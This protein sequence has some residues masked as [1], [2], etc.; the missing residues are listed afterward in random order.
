MYV[1]IAAKKPEL[2]AFV[3]I[4]ETSRR[5]RVRLHYVFSTDSVLGLLTT[6]GNNPIETLYVRFERKL[7]PGLN[8]FS[9]SSLASCLSYNRM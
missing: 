5:Q 6:D 1:I 2:K 7:F 8:S 3:A 9:Q 4:S